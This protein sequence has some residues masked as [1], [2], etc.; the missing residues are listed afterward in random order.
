MHSPGIHLVK[1]SPNSGRR[2]LRETAA[3]VQ[4]SLVKAL[5]VHE[6]AHRS[7]IG[8]FPNFDHLA[9][10]REP[11]FDVAVGAALGTSR[12]RWCEPGRAKLV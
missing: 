11:T 4:S 9:A 1:R 8:N 6:N 2:D 10:G 7:A 3:T 5:G 12:A